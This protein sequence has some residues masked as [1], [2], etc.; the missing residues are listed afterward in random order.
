[1]VPMSDAQAH[2]IPHF[3]MRHRLDLALETADVSIQE[4]SAELGVHRNTVSNYLSGRTLP[5]T[6]AVKVWA[7]R[8][9]VPYEW[10]RTG[11]EPHDGGPSAPGD[12][13]GS[14]S[15]Q[16]TNRTKLAAV[17]PLRSAQPLA[18]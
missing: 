7:L 12:Q 18:A 13:G 6:S 2:G 8:C 10:L 17:L 15:G 1:M 11:L 9:G 16:K 4:M 14:P 5:P 3:Q